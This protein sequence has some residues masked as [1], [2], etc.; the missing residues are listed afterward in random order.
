MSLSPVLITLFGA[1]GDLAKRKLYRSIFSLYQKESIPED[2]FAVI[3]TGRRKWSDNYYRTIISDSI[4]DLSDDWEEIS[5]FVSHFYYLSQD[6]TDRDHYSVLYDK[7]EELDEKY[8]T[9]GNHLFYLSM[10]PHFFGIIANHLNDYGFINR[11]R[12]FNRLVIEKPFGSDY[13]TA[14]QLNDELTHSFLEDEIFRVDHYLG[15]ATV[16]NILT[17][18]QANAMIESLMNRQFV[19][20]IQ[21]S[22]LEDMGIGTRGSYYDATGAS[23]D[24]LQNH[25]LQLISLILMDL[26][27]ED[28]SECIHR[29][30]EKVLQE[31]ELIT[32]DNVN[33]RIVRGQY[34]ADDP[35]N[36]AYCDELD[37][38]S[39][40]I[41]ET[42]ISGYFS[43]DNDRWQ[44]VPVYFRTGKQLAEKLSVVHVVFKN[45]FALK[46]A[47]QKENVLSFY[48]SGDR[49]VQLRLN[50]ISS[51]PK[52]HNESVPLNYS[53]VGEQLAAFADDYEFI[54]Y[55]SI[56]GRNE[57]FVHWSEL[58]QSWKIVDSIRS[59]WKAH[60]APDFP[61]YEVGSV[62]PYAS[63]MMLRQNDSAWLY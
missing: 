23:R 54:L 44:G 36:T 28:T 53:K 40:S 19:K 12:G 63:D 31:I 34:G 49:G 3:G 24:M 9:G 13:E 20:E 61:N 2:N 43:I 62:G 33:D 60:S 16:K 38:D 25:I 39:D 51:N 6:V 29:A 52:R 55:D 21:V 57:N 30:K 18:R 15:K 27:E 11:D 1:T 8:Q 41:T 46:D 14:K 42:Y 48:L 45:Q 17:V 32:K 37:V 47:K 5:E 56:A 22:L 59:S 26:P 10:A 35:T 58:A 7:V 4:K 50:T